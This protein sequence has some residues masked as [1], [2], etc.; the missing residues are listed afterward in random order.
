MKKIVTFLISA[1][2]FFI[3]INLSAQT[4][5]NQTDGC[6]FR[7][8]LVSVLGTGWQSAYS[9]NITVDD[10]DY[11]FVRLPWGTPSAEKILQLPS[12]KVQFF[13]V[14]GTFNNYEHYF[15]IYNSFNELIYTSPN[16]IHPVGLLFTYQNECPECVSLTDFEGEYNQ[17]TKLV[18]LSWI[19]PDSENLTGFNILRNGVLLEFVASTITSYVLQTDT[20][21]TGDYKFCVVPVY[22]YICDLEEKCFETYIENLG[23]KKY[24]S[25]LSL[26]PNPANNIVHIAGENVANVKV[27]NKMGQL[28]NN[29][30]NTNH[31]D[32]SLYP[33]GIY[34]FNIATTKGDFGAYKIVVTK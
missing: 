10:I 13:W 23:V 29:Y 2:L 19:V 26:Y 17:E 21:A 8:V 16:D 22:P 34:I 20:L 24:S 12:G 6:Y 7:F 11:G 1:T 18:N 14:G 33:A 27:F 4:E 28:I 30:N 3:S 32:V 15:E 5:R 31:I 25:A 9:I